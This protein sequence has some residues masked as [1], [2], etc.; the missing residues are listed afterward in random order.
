MFTTAKVRSL[1]VDGRLLRVAVRPAR[2]GFPVRAGTRRVPLLLINGIGAS[3]ELLEP[4]VRELDPGLEV[5]RFDPPGV[6][7]SAQPSAPYRFTGLCALI[8]SML[9]QLD[10][11][12]VD[13]LGIS[14]GGAVAQHFA[15][16]Q[17]ARCRRLV[18]V[19]TATGSLMIPARPSVLAHMV[20][21]RRYLDRGYLER[22]AGS[23][24]G[25]SAREQP[26]RVAAAMNNGNRVGPS[27]GYLYQLTAGAGWT[28]L[29]FLPLLRQPTLILAGDDDPIIPLANARLMKLLIPKSRLHV[30]HGGHLGLVTEAAELA[31]VVDAFLAAP[32]P[33]WRFVMTRTAVTDAD[34]YLI[35]QTLETGG[36]D[37]LHRVREFMEKSVQ[38][39]INHYWTREEFP[40]DLVVPGLRDLGITGQAYTGY[41]C[42]GGGNLLDGM[43]AMELARV[44][45]SIA[46]FFGVHSGLAM[47]SIYLC[48]SEEQKQRWLPEMAR[49][50][51]IGAFGLTE[52]E[53]GSGAAGGLTTTARREGDE[54]VLDGQKKW[55]GNATFADYVVIWARDIADQQVKGFVVT[56]GT[57]GFLTAKMRDKIALRVV[58]NAHITLDGVRVPESHR[59]QAANSFRDT[60]AVLRMTR[61]GVAWMATGCARGAYEHALAY[62]RQRQQFGRTIAGFQLVQDL[63]V[64]MLANVTSSACLC[65][66]LA[67]LQQDGLAE[68]HH[69]ALAKAFCTVRMREAVGWARELLG[70]NGILLENH[71]GRFVADSEA[72]YS[73]E[74]TREINTLIVGRAITGTSAFV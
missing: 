35:E 44:D 16:F 47:G 14:W 41:G 70:G 64:R 55:I 28:S 53:V 67:A 6:G 56:R 60:A 42:P 22:V 51:K 7:G 5:I 17:R 9:T 29:P 74:G 33:V 13:V 68:D 45:P 43:I 25:G 40:Y 58:Q 24:Y 59:L 20:T 21:P 48:G 8:A 30:Y 38:P 50:D 66:R 65:A 3:L 46:T 34:F 27:R 4:F 23:I 11:D 39:V 73:Y 32:L 36:R 18:L 1:A 26:E 12:V 49:M 61:A 54:W 10:V 62:A 37:L 72:I 31:P 69:S 57:P 52:P 2:R 63:L 15:A 71:V 19:S